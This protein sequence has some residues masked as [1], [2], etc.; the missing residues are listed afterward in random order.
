MNFLP[1]YKTH[2]LV[3]SG[4][5]VI[6]FSYLG[7]GMDLSAAVQRSLEVLSISTLRMGVA[8]PTAAK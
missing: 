4:L 6:W 5:G 8:S 2:A 1:G 7:G 3:V